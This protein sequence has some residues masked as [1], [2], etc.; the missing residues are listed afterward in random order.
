MV[1]EYL[2][3]FALGLAFGMV[4]FS[5]IIARIKGVD[6]KQQG[7][8]N[9]GATN[10]GRSLGLPFFIAGFLLDGLKGLA[11]VLLAR[12]WYWVPAAAGMG[13]ILGHIFN[14]LFNF[15]GGKGV[16][17]TIG[18]TLGL[19]PKAFLVSLAVWVIVYL[20]TFFVSLASLGFAVVLPIS[21][22]ILKESCLVDRI[23]VLVI[24]VLIWFA[25]RSN[26]QRLFKK[27]EPKTVLWRK[28]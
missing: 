9:I 25:H 28:K 21:A 6:L 12:S 20:A 5:Y 18:V 3:A 11:P 4:P 16:S 13:A 19:V 27:D 26:I 8:G 17:T 14:P 15:K 7:S 23:F 10:L 22:F 1:K 2:F 24:T